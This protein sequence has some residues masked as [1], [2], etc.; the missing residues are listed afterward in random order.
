VQEF[1]AESN[2]ETITEVNAKKTKFAADAALELV[3]AST[4]LY[5]TRGKHVVHFKLKQDHPG[6][7]EIL[8]LILGPSGNLRA[9]TIRIGR[10]LVVGFNEELFRKIFDQQ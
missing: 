5:V 2:A 1:L 7:D 3:N 9:P 10:N 4:D 6:D 8:K